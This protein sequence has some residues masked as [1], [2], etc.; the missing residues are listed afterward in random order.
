[1]KKILFLFAFISIVCSSYSQEIYLITR[2]DD[3]GSFHSANKACLD[4]S[5]KGI[6][7]SI[8]VMSCCDWFPEAVEFL[9]TK[10]TL[11]DVGVHIMLTSEWSNVK[12][13]PMTEARSIVDANGFFFPFLTHRNN[14]EKQYPCLANQNWDLKEIENEIRAQVEHAKKAIPRISHIS[15]HMGSCQLSKEV[16]Q[17]S[18]KIAKEYGIDIDMSGVKRLETHININDSYE[19]WE[20]KF[21]DAINKMTAGTYL[22]VEHPAYNT[23]E[24]ESVGHIG[25]MNV[26]EHRQKVIQLFLS[27]KVKAAIQKK[28]VKLIS[29]ADWK[30]MNP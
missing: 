8:E 4:A 1:M 22:F 27:P 7:K 21:I 16:E 20:N 2:A 30:K 11:V 24:M 18:K 28:N 29:Y 13:R 17:V 23:D 5:T 15:A 9:N 6:V 12:W 19:V 14:L 10:D 25:Y 26:G 3:M